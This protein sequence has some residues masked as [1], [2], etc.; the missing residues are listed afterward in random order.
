M[1]KDPFL[2]VRPSLNDSVLVQQGLV[3]E[4]TLPQ[5]THSARDIQVYFR[6]RLLTC[7]YDRTVMS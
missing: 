2:V 4:T 3:E 7:Y 1:T 6:M 5:P